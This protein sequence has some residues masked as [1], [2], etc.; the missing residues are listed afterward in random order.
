MKK[1]FKVMG[2]SAMMAAAMAISAS[3]ATITNVKFACGAPEDD[4]ITDGYTAPEFTADEA[5]GYELSSVTDLKEDGNYKNAH[6]FELVFNAVDGNTFPDGNSVTVSGS[7]I[8]EITR[9]KMED[10]GD[11]LVVR[12]KAYVYYRLD[13]PDELEHDDAGKKMVWKKGN[14]SNFEYILTYTDQNGEDQVK[15]GTTSSSSMSTK[16]YEKELSEK[17][18]EKED[19]EKVD[20]ELT[21]FAI[22]AISSNTN[23]PRVAP[24]A[25]AVWGSDPAGGACACVLHA[26]RPRL[27]DPTG[28][29]TLVFLRAL[30]QG[31]SDVSAA[32]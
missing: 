3:A 22:R 24:S 29:Q 10:D 17:Q 28:K 16:N 7:G 12:C 13:T 11:T 5:D 4:T 25:W 31:R 18:K 21:G 23:N 26:A 2:I 20:M 19:N 6:T 27:G 15:K 1:I 9:K 30:S 8:T 14:G 32:L